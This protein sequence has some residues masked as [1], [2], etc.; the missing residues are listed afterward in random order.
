MPASNLAATDPV[1]E[2]RGVVVHVAHDFVIGTV[3]SHAN[4]LRFVGVMNHRVGVPELDGNFRQSYVQSRNF[5]VFAS[6]ENRQQQKRALGHKPRFSVALER[7]QINA[8]VDVTLRSFERVKAKNS[9]AETA[10]EAKLCSIMMAGV[11]KQKKPQANAQQRG[12]SA[13]GFT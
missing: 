3:S 2:K 12:T 1:V 6:A 9:L 10:S 5:G 8:E 11:Q 4:F 7:I 13:R